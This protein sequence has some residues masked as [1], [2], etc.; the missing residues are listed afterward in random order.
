MPTADYKIYILRIQGYILQKYKVYSPVPWKKVKSFFSTFFKKVLKKILKRLKSRLVVVFITV[1]SY[2]FSNIFKMFWHFWKILKLTN[3]FPRISLRYDVYSPIIPWRLSWRIYTPVM[4][5]VQ[6]LSPSKRNQ[7]A[8]FHHLQAVQRLFGWTED[9]GPFGANRMP[10]RSQP[11]HD[12]LLLTNFFNLLL[13]SFP[14][15]L[16]HLAGLEGE[17]VYIL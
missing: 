3:L 16:L 8:D 9:L 5:L 7:S 4:S 1:L 14:H 13:N 17:G 2:N 15:W 12:Q 6:Q 10:S 11:H